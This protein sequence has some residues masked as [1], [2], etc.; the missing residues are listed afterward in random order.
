MFDNQ[1]FFLVQGASLFIYIGSHLAL[2]YKSSIWRYKFIMS[3]WY[4]RIFSL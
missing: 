2:N 3:P 1:L 4:C